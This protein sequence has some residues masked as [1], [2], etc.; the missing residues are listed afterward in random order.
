MMAN[1]FLFR[2]APAMGYTPAHRK[3]TRERILESAA[4][5]FRTR[6]YDAAS[7][8]DIMS[9]AGLT[10][11]GFYLHFD[12]KEDLFAAYV[13]RELDFGRQVRQAMERRP[14]APLRGAGEAL[15]FYLTPGHRKRIAKGCTIVSNAADVARSSAK[16]R[17]A[18]T[19]AF[20][21]MRQEFTGVAEGAD[22]PD[23]A[24]LAAIATSV[25]GV[26]LARAL[27]DEA[28]VERLLAAC[29]HAVARELG[30][31]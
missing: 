18:F 17:R 3:A 11:G 24:A 23:A 28:L 13:G 5:L 19:R 14:E 26:V 25:G 30:E 16:A 7:I 9:G 10:R 21:G 12:S 31:G 8:D 15:D 29:R 27:S 20:E 22:D 1:I 2:D 6:G 4:Q